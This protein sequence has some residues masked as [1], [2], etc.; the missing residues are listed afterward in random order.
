VS[1]TAFMRADR[2]ESALLVRVVERAAEYRL[3]LDKRMAR[4]VVT[5]LAEAVKRGRG[6]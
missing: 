3:A 6:R 5:E 4:L 1:P 2:V